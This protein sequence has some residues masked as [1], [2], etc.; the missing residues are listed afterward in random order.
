MFSAG[1]LT[2]AASLVMSLGAPAAAQLDGAFTLR[3]SE[4][5]RLQ[6]NFTYQDGRSN[7]GRPF[8]RSALADVSQQGEKVTF[9]MR[10]PAGSFAFEGRGTIERAAGWY[11][12][13]PSAEFRREMEKMGF[14]GLEDKH[15]FVFA[16]D[17]LSAAGVRQLQGLLADRI[18]SEG[19]VR[20]INHGAGLRYV[21]E[22]TDAG[23]VKLTSDE[24]RRARDHGV[25]AQYAKE[26][27]QQFGIK[28]SLPELVRLRDHGV[29]LSFVRE[30]KEAGFDVG[31]EDLVRARD[32]GVNPEFV[33]R[34]TALGY[35]GLELSEYIRMR[36]HGVSPQYVE[37]LRSAGLDKVPAREL[38]RLRD[39]GISA[40][41][42][43][44]MRELFK[45][46]PT[47]EQIIRLRTRGDL[48]R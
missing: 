40:N 47:A 8:D 18:D 15:L 25:S 27:M 32:H 42:V 46:P 39:H 4:D 34:M 16:L 37:E 43:K 24:Y 45:E 7:W 11:V 13:T 2:L 41:Y 20:L 31:L 14:T 3:Q 22:M 26:M 5:G 28:P 36:D 44:R 38:T 10:R 19:L 17:D 9:A 29:S 30:M 12:F 35:G 23:F 6:L 21:Q 1:R 33:S 48:P